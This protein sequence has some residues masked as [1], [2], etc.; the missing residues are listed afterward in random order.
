[1]SWIYLIITISLLLPYWVGVFYMYWN[2]RRES[3]FCVGTQTPLLSLSV[4]IPFRN[5]ET[6]LPRLIE[7]LKAQTY[8]SI[9]TEFF[10]VN[11]H[12]TDKSDVIA[13]ELT[14]ADNRFNILSLPENKLGKKQALEFA[15]TQTKG[16]FIIQTD[17]DCT[18]SKDWLTSIAYYAQVTQADLIIA[19]V[20]IQAEN[21]LF[22][23]LQSIEFAS[24]SSIVAGGTIANKPLLINAANMA[25]RR[26]ALEQI[27]NPFKREKAS[28]DDQFLLQAM[29]QNKMK[30]AYLKSETAIVK[31]KALPSYHHFF[32]Q[33]VRWASK[34]SAY[35]GTLIKATAILIF[36]LNLWIVFLFFVGLVNY[37]LLSL[38][39]ITL[40]L[41]SVVD[42]PLLSHFQKW[43]KQPFT[44]SLFILT[45]LLYSFYTTFTSLW[46]FTHSVKWK[47]RKVY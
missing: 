3:D 4:I 22:S 24:L 13:K 21:S 6:N 17:A 26:T 1:M 14:T 28:G 46:A 18:M 5:E 44:V 32:Q 43:S 2:W 10:L 33:R 29:L 42:Y 23:K 27:S 39:F 25:Y 20:V 8:P 12:S 40:L 9:Q 34:S 19:P 36:M 37:H 47:Q 7:A 41:K 11:D 38:W 30:I 16:E 35:N 45:Q 31:T 15:L